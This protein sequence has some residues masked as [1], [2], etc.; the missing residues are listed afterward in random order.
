[1]KKKLHKAERDLRNLKDTN[2]TKGKLHMEEMVRMR[3]KDHFSVATLDLIMDKNRKFSQK[4]TNKDF[5]LPI[6]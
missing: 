3:L 5:R 6:C 4:W 2:T 1:M